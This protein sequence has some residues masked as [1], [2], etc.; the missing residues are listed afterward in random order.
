MVLTDW[1]KK[2][3]VSMAALYMRHTPFSKGRWRLTHTFLPLLR[4]IG[5]SMGKRCV[6]TRR[7]FKINV[8]LGEWIGQQIYMTGDFEPATTS[9]ICSV[10]Q[11]GDTV[12]DV[13]ANIGFITLAAARKVGNSGMVVAFEPVSSTCASLKGNLSLNG[14]TNVVVHEIALSDRNGMVTIHEG[15]ARNKGTSSIRP[16]SNSSGQQTVT[17]AAFDSLDVSSGPIRLIKIDVEGAEQL[18]VEGMTECLR[19]HRPHLVLEVTPAFLRDF[20]HSEVSLCKK[21]TDIGYRMYDIADHGPIS[22]PDDSGLW[23]TQ[24]NALFSFDFHL[25]KDG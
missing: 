25:R 18:V 14:A 7:G 9:L 8:D 3:A 15:P 6:T 21:L 16:I 5:K 13:G 12:V 11:E 4:D 19:R 10:I 23:P 2:L 22:M 17:T 24:F 20:G 1:P